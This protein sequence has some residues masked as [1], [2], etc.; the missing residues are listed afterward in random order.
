MAQPVP[1]PIKN[2]Q[3]NPLRVPNQPGDHD[4]LLDYILLA[5]MI[6]F[7]P[8]C[9]PTLDLMTDVIQTTFTLLNMSTRYLF[10]KLTAVHQL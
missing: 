2:V 6:Q 8:F 9:S 4:I 5:S 1:T 7:A 3:I 10:S